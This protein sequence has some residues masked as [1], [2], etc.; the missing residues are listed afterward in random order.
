MDK[1][2]QLLLHTH[3][4]QQEIES[5]VAGCFSSYTPLQ[6]IELG[7]TWPEREATDLPLL[8]ARYTV[9]DNFDTRLCLMRALQRVYSLEDVLDV[10]SEHGFSLIGDEQLVSL[11]R[12]RL[13]ERLHEIA[14]LTDMECF[15]EEADAVGEGE[16]PSSIMGRDALAGIFDD[17]GSDGEERAML[18]KYFL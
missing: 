6:D 16:N 13:V 8:H 5:D 18:R 10:I 14:E 11:V 9:E 3:Y 1:N 12:K 4:N 15:L 7:F 17:L 2:F